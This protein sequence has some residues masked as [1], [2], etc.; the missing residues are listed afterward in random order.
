M[1]LID[2]HVSVGRRVAV[3]RVYVHTGPAGH[4]AMTVNNLTVAGAPAWSS[5][6][7]CIHEARPYQGLEIWN[8][9][10]NALLDPDLYHRNITT[11]DRR[12]VETSSYP[13]SK[14]A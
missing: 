6:Y 5:F 7:M 13:T 14:G 2:L 12:T 9:S 1:R 4:D 10:A 8:D 3:S 11:L